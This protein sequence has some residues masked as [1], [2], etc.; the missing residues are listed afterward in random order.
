[1]R[2]PTRGRPGSP[3]SPRPTRGEA[4]PLE[5]SG[6]RRRQPQPQPQPLTHARCHLPP[7]PPHSARESGACW[8]CWA[9][10]P[11]WG[12]RAA[13][14]R[15]C[16]RPGGCPQTAHSSCPRRRTG[17]PP[18]PPAPFPPLSLPFSATPALFSARR[19]R[20]HTAAAAGEVTGWLAGWV[21][22]EE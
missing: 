10:L 14:P 21:A 4:E 2:E 1:M 3:V 22:G 6:W 15:S 11:R 12:R 18:P 20:A 9:E 5:P 19:V 8:S 7:H 13:R 16:R 17:S